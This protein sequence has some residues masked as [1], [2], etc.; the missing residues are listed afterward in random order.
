MSENL[1][2]EITKLI[3]LADKDQKLLTK[4]NSDGPHTATEVEEWEKLRRTNVN[5]LKSLEPKY[6]LISSKKYGDKAYK[7]AYLIVL[8][9]PEEDVAYMEHYLS[10]MQTEDGGVDEYMAYLTDKIALQKGRPQIY[11]TQVTFN[12]HTGKYEPYKL[13]DPEETARLRDQLK[14]EPLEKYVAWFNG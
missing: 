8:H 2:S 12:E 4:I 13:K 9:A 11:G 1:T 14:L 6:G 10:L 3:A 5:F 7:A